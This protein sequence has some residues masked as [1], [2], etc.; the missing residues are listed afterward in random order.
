[1]C[2][3]DAPEAPD[4]RLPMITYPVA[5]LPARSQNLGDLIGTTR[6]EILAE[7]TQPQSTEGLA[8]RL[9]LSRATVSYHLQILHRAGLLQ[10]TRRSRH[11]YYQRASP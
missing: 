11:V 10:R 1:M 2:C 5:A 9:H 6:A 3:T 7:L 4:A 8:Q